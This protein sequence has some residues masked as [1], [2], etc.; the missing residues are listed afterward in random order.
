MVLAISYYAEL[1]LNIRAVTVSILLPSPTSAETYFEL[2]E[3][4]KSV[5]LFHEDQEACIQLPAKVLPAK[6][7]SSNSCTTTLNLRLQLDNGE[8]SLHKE[9]EPAENVYPWT[10][11]SLQAS[12]TLNCCVC[13]NIFTPDNAIKQWKDLPSENWAEMM[14]FWHCHK[15]DEPEQGDPSEATAAK[16]YSASNH[17]SARS[18][19]GFLD[20]CHVLLHREDCSGLKVFTSLLWNVHWNI[21]HQEGGLF[22]PCRYN[23]WL[24]DTNAL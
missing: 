7:P 20:V 8:P 2:A 1:L 18:G 4:C 22:R 10:A 19:T 24:S 23:E 9:N 13:G 15:P 21:G 6:I 5:T 17:L 12:S 16:G 11:S 3:D 14:D